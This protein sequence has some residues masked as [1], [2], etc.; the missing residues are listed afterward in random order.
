M[1]AHPPHYTSHPSGVEVVSYTRLL[2]FGPGNAV[3]YVMRRDEKGTAR[4]DLE[5]ALW[6]LDDCL[7]TN[8]GFYDQT[9]EMRRIVLPVVVAEPHP[10]VREFL[11]RIYLLESSDR[12]GTYPALPDARDTLVELL[13]EYPND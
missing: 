6:Y 10:L 12:G 4:Q 5:K 2:P 11:A 3:K 8:S 13:K 7:N 9:P 1:V